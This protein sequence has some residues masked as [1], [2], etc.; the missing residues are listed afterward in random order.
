MK[1]IKLLI[2]TVVV[3]V[4]FF[5]SVQ[6]QKINNGK[7]Q[8]TVSVAALKFSSVV[9]ENQ[10]GK[11][12]LMVKDIEHRS[13]VAHQYNVVP[14][15]RG[16]EMFFKQK[17]D[18]LLPAPSYM[19]FYQGYDVIFSETY[20]VVTYQAFTLADDTI[21]TNKN[22]LKNKVI[23]VIRDRSSWDFQKRFGVKGNTFV[24]VNDLKALVG[25]LNKKHIDV[26][27]HGKGFL[28]LNKKLGYP[29]PNYAQE[30]PIAIDKLTIVCHKNDANNRY[31]QAINP[32]IRE[33][34]QGG[35]MKR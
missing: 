32:F 8:I 19:P 16:A 25:M 15:A 5:C 4:S 34:V 29:M 33:I 1:Y 2:F 10:D 20:S 31:I 13:G 7:N 3:I 14:T 18:C 28:K 35:Q 27:I 17:V 24:K 21:I 12:D 30:H 6:A 23:G 9:T 22:Q 26:V 11:F